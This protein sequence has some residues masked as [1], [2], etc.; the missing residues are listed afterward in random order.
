MISSVKRSPITWDTVVE[1][2][3]NVQV[4]VAF[5]D[6]VIRQSSTSTLAIKRFGHTLVDLA[7]QGGA[8]R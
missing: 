7:E 6:V 8:T 5:H 4:D 3:V 2:N 1:H